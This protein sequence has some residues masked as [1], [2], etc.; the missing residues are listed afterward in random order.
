MSPW[1]SR[2][3]T[4]RGRALAVGATAFADGTLAVVRGTELQIVAND[5]SIKQSLRAAEEL[6]T[7]PAIG[8][9]GAVWVASARTLYVAR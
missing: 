1:R 3:S 6:T 7:Y 5:G 8:P 4:A 9:D 2:H